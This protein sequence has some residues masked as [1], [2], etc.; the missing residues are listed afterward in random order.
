MAAGLLAKGPDAV[1]S[2]SK[3][4]GQIAEAGRV[5]A[6]A[7]AG[8]YY[9]QGISSV[10]HLIDGMK[11]KEV[12]LQAQVA[13]IAD[14]MLNLN[15]GQINAAT[16]LGELKAVSPGA[17]GPLRG[18]IAR[19]GTASGG[20]VVHHTTMQITLDGRVVAENTRTHLLKTKDRIGTLGLA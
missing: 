6:D 20:T 1:L 13:R 11:S 17:V 10:Q 12:L 4:M 9:D 5:A 19:S 3:L 18:D 16:A 15:K 14:I 8:Q 2:V 7:I